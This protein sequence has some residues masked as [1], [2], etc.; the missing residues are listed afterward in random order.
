M[1]NSSKALLM[2]AEVLVGVLLLSLM[3]TLIYVF[4][5][6]QAEITTNQAQK[7]IYE[8][9]ARFQGFEN[10]DLTAQDVLSLYNLTKDYN[11]KFDGEI[12]IS[13]KVQGITNKEI[14]ASSDFLNA[15]NK[16]TY[17]ITKIEYNNADGK[18]KSINIKE[19]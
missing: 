4:T 19:K 2:A 5:N 16:K 6:Y 9:N 7:D 3:A 11:K 17:V 15:D 18:V 1:E 10:K 13:M 8:F 14:T 12:R